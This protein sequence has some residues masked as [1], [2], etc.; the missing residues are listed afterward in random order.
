MSTISRVAWLVPLV[1]SVT[2]VG[3]TIVDNGGPDYAFGL[4]ITT[5][6][7]ADDFVLAAPATIA[8]IRFWA[9]TFTP[10]SS[11]TITWA[12][13]TDSG[14]MLGGLISSGTLS[15]VPL[16]DTGFTLQDPCHLCPVSL[17]DLSIAP[18]LLASGHYWLELHGGV[19]LTATDP[20]F[21]TAWVSTSIV[22]N[23]SVK[24]DQTPTLPNSP[25]GRDVAFQ[26]FDAAVPEPSTWIL[27]TIGIL[28]IAT[29]RWRG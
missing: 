10:E 9:A 25:V 28:G 17:V 20:T 18:L 11:R 24:Q 7:A 16:Q 27:F 5:F 12:F 21:D 14:N 29:R 3:A 23:F 1:V 26:L 15:G 19:D 22:K 13:Y 4:S 2:A 6:R 8:G